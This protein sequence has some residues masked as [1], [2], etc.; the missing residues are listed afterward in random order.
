MSTFADFLAVCMT[1][2]R[3]VVAGPIC[4]ACKC[5]MGT[6]APTVDEAMLDAVLAQQ[7]IR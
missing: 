2:G 3:S 5:E 6:K 7:G 1:C 4:A